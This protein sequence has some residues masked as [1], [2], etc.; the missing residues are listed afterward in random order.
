MAKRVVVV[1]AGISGLTC[2]YR[3]QRS[4]LDVI[5][6]ESS[7][8]AGGVIQTDNEHGF[9]CEVGPNSFHGTPEAFELIRSL[10]T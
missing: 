9:L 7:D 6:L 4:G 10:R 1:G 5:V 8:A 3:L 2:A